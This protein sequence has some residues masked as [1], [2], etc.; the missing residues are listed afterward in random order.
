[1]YNLLEDN[2]QNKHVVVVHK[3]EDRDIFI[4]KLKYPKTVYHVGD[5]PEDDDIQIDP[6][7]GFPAIMATWILDNYEN[8]PDYVIFAQANPYDHVIEPLLAI[9]STLTANWGSFCFARSMYDQYS[10]N[11]V[12]YNPVRSILH[13]FDIKFI[14]DN[15]VSKFI[16]MFY[17]GDHF[18]ISKKRM[19][20]KPRS[21]Y[22]KFI[23]WD[24]QENFFNLVYSEKKPLHFWQS[25]DANF[26]EYKKLSREEKFNRIAAPLPNRNYGYFGY[27]TEVILSYLFGDEDFLRTINLGQA[28]IGNKLYFDT[29]KQSYNSNF[30]F[31]RY[32]FSHQISTT[33][34]NFKKFEN[35]WFD[36]DCPYYLKWR[37]A[38]AKTLIS[39]G[40]RMG[41]DGQNLLDYFVKIGYKHISL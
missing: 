28:C 33:M 5:N 11:W 21:F 34:F 41:F 2:M 30:N 8:L 39:E 24:K 16:Y 7:M 36:W 9:D 14:N 15:N 13:E 3:N 32:P 37:E 17:P 18:Y 40:E 12:R 22:E 1:M 6:T 38:L 10:T 26:P 35:N 23:Y 25:I 27:T 29:N 20:E 31:W 4:N 19:L